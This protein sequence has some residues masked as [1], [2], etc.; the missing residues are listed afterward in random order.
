MIELFIEN[1]NTNQGKW[2]VLPISWNEVKTQIKLDDTTDYLVT[3]YIAPFTISHFT[4]FNLM[5]ELAE[6]MDEYTNHPSAKY[7]VEIVEYGF[8]SD[9]NEAFENIDN[10]IV[11]EDCYSY[12]E[13]AERLVD[14]LGY[15][16]G[17]PDLIKWNIDYEGIGRDLRYDS[18]LYQAN[19][20]IIIEVT[21]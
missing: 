17:V 11:Y 18:N 10:I 4:D 6:M 13:Y 20:N 1:L 8:Y 12:K 7:I 9:F 16:S 21:S 5:N 14:E 2:F 19:D 3:D 15:L